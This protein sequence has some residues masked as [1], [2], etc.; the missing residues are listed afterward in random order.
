[1]LPGRT[2]RILDT[3]DLISDLT[4]SARRYGEKIHLKMSFDEEIELFRQYD[5]VLLIQE[6]DYN[7]ICRILGSDMCILAPH[8][9]ELRP[10]EIRRSVSNIGLVASKWVANVDGLKWFLRRVWR[11]VVRPGVTLNVYGAICEEMREPVGL[12]GVIRSL[13]DR[14]EMSG[15]VFRGVLP[16]LN[17]IYDEI[18][19]VINPV[20]IGAGLK[21]KN[22]E[23]LGAGLPLVTTSEGARGLEAVVGKGC[24]VGDSPRM[25]ASHLVRLIDDY[26]LRRSL[27]ESGYSFASTRLSE[28]ACYSQLLEEIN[29][30]YQRATERE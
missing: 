27:G 11:S 2:K 4:R 20:R 29:R 23:A 17:R 13:V 25:F 22:V 5:T 15:V 3:H 19:I 7:Q 28:H 8:P 9:P 6:R 16:E 14:R 24:L 1:M 18:D 26:Q 10:R 30:T 21:I 12:L